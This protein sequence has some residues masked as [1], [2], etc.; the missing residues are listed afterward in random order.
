M[1]KTKTVFVVGAG[2]SAEV[3]LPVGEALKDRIA[4]LLSYRW[5]Q[6]KNR[7]TSGDVDIAAAIQKKALSAGSIDDE[8]KLFQ[9][10][11]AISNAMPQSISIDNF[12]DAHSGDEFITFVGKLGIAASILKAERTSKIHIDRSNA[13]NRVD[14]R[15][16]KDIWHNLFCR[17]ATAEMKRGNLQGIFENVVIVTFNYDRCIEHYVSEWLATYFVIPAAD[18]QAIT[19]TLQI[20]HPYGRIGELPW[21]RSDANGLDFGADASGEVLIEA[22]QQL[23]TFTERASDFNMIN[24]MKSHLTIADKIIYLG[25]S[26]GPM[27]MELM[28]PSGKSAARTVLATCLGVS[29]PNRRRIDSLILKTV[30]PRDPLLV[31]RQYL[32]GSFLQLLQDHW[33]DI[34]S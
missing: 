8:N 34:S 24:E 20:Y 30:N 31:E 3:G 6:G 14:F 25:F 22:A 32:A 9:A 15:G 1:F 29:E 27:N 17:M 19:S 12:L 7:L 16:T 10:A 4:E 2:G 28:R 11:R 21:Q 23:R 5:A 33:Q 26:F 18:A 13:Y